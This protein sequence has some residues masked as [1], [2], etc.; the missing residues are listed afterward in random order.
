MEVD[1]DELEVDG[2]LRDDE[3]DG[4]CDAEDL[5]GTDLL[6]LLDGRAILKSGA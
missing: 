2:M 6:S 1:A 5:F 4:A 3:A